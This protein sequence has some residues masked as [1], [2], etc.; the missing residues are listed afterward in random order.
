MR[1]SV[2][3]AR[4]QVFVMRPLLMSF[5][6][7]KDDDDTSY[8]IDIAACYLHGRMNVYFFG[9]IFVLLTPFLVA[10]GGTLDF[11]DI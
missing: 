1:R 5:T 7:T 8:Q 9:C 4:A 3:S 10:F 11:R 2:R 6:R